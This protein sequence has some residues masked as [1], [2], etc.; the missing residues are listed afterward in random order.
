MQK[1]KVRINIDEFPQEIRCFMQ[2][3]NIY[4][5]S[6]HS[7]AKVF[8]ID[9]GYYLK[10]DKKGSMKREAE[11]TKIF[12]E[13]GLGVELLFYISKEKDYMLTRSAV[14]EDA[15]SY[16]DTPRKICEVMAKT[17]LDLH[18]LS[19]N[20]IPESARMQQYKNSS[21]KEFIQKL[22]CD[23][24]I[25]GDFC[26]PNIILDNGEFSTLIDFSMSGIGDKHIDLY[27]AIWSLDFNLETD[28]YTDY[29]LDLY[30]RDNFDE[31]ML[32]VIAM[33]EAAE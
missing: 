13:I 23:T 7:S 5:S 15:I 29:F 25:H 6:C 19:T 2:N 9:T 11:L 3:A 12:Y 10:I 33:L 26:L 4:D 28:E 24:L 27:W 30:G 8:Y 32:K 17:L 20:E 14:G 22:K 21:K 16:L 31:K 18:S 1:T